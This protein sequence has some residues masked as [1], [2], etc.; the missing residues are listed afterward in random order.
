MR[1]MNT[2]V[3]VIF[4]STL[5]FAD[6]TCAV[7]YDANTSK[8]KEIQCHCVCDKKLSKE[9]KMTEALEFYKNSKIYKFSKFRFLN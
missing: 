9:E 3:S 6:S 8:T 1:F 2:I 5:L 4:T 7:D